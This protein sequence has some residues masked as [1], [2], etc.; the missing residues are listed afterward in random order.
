MNLRHRLFILNDPR[1]T[2]QSDYRYCIVSVASTDMV[3][4]Y[5]WTHTTKT[6]YKRALDEGILE[7]SREDAPDLYL[8]V[9]REMQ[10][11]FDAVMRR[12]HEKQEPVQ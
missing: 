10:N 3:T 12:V 4:S 11:K 6:G 1:G 5:C 7:L 2:G 9:V 8:A